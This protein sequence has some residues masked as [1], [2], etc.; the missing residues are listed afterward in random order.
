M[1]KANI[2][3]LQQLVDQGYLT[4][5]PHPTADLVIWNYTPKTQYEQYWTEETM[6]CRGLITKPDG[7]IVARPFRKF[8]NIEQHEGPIPLEPFTVTEKVD[9]SLAIMY[10]IDNKPYIATRGSFTSDQAIKANEILYSK[11]RGIAG[12]FQSCYTYLLEILYPENRIVVN[13]GN[14]EDLVLLAIINTE[15]G[16]E[17]DI[18][19]PDFI[20]FC[21]V[22]L[23][24]IV[25]LYD[26]IKD[27]NELK[28]L[29]E[30]NKEGFVIRFESGLRLKCKF[31]SYIRLHKILTQCTS[32][33]IWEL[34]RNNQAFDDLLQKVP[35][36]FYKWAQA[37]KNNLQSQYD[38]I[39]SYAQEVHSKVKDLPTRKE[40]ATIVCKHPH[41]AVVFSML[42]GK[43]YADTIWKQ[44]RPQAEKPFKNEEETQ[45]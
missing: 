3:T 15:T 29:E 34:L 9:G 30:P 42:D 20:K 16:E 10:F 24:P 25:K 35:D 40:Q 1:S 31:E 45:G 38:S 41:S 6:M 14:T 7:T 32:R 2:D 37:T 19:S 22:D 11:Y 5:R 13:Y 17:L 8:H 4:C 33:T 39:E 23:F 26:G 28:K 27:I 21:G 12:L 18:H 36:E 44:L 43:P